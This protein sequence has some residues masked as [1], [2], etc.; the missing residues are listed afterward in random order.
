MLESQETN[1]WL[2]TAKI[3]APV[4]ST[5]ALGWWISRHTE[6]YK[7]DL[8]K[9]IHRFQTVH[10]RRLDIFGSLLK[11]AR[12]VQSELNGCL[13]NI[14]GIGYFY[15][16]NEE[17]QEQELSGRTGAVSTSLRELKETVESNRM[18]FDPETVAFLDEMQSK[19]SEARLFFVRIYNEDTGESRVPA[20]TPE[21]YEKAKDSVTRTVPDLIVE[22]ESRMRASLES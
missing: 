1:W 17:W 3:A 5:I 22:L 8:A 14:D 18:L 10:P 19:M 6:K 12:I 13:D 7:S 2:E 4:V 9:E 16:G 11:T 15:R 20:K 21:G